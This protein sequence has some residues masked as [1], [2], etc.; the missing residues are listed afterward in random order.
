MQWTVVIALVVVAVSV[1]SIAV[2][3]AAHSPWHVLIGPAPVHTVLD[4]SL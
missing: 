3:D 4:A 2:L 1:A